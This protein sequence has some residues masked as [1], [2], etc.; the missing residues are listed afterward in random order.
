M[1]V[2]QLVSEPVAHLTRANTERSF[3]LIV[4]NPVQVRTSVR[5]AV[6]HVT[7]S[8]SPASARG[9]PMARGSVTR[10][11]PREE[12]ARKP[13]LVY[14]GLTIPFILVVTCFAAWGS[15]ANLTDVLVGVF[16][17]I[18]AM[19]NFPLALDQFAS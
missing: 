3:S 17:H 8:P 9:D 13:G 1:S 11:Q 19:S 14:P 18:F 4:W 15:A 5:T 10:V 12:G 7:R 2:S 6:A 16:R